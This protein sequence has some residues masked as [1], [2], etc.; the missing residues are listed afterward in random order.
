MLAC[1]LVAKAQYKVDK[2]DGKCYMAGACIVENSTDNDLFANIVLRVQK[3]SESSGME[4]FSKIDFNARHLEVPIEAKMKNASFTGTLRVDVY[5][6][7][8][9]FRI[10]EIVQHTTVL[11]SPKLTPLEK[12]QPERKPAHKAA[13]AEFEEKESE[14]LRDMQNFAKTNQLPNITHWDEIRSGKIV[15]GMNE[16]ECQLAVGKPR[17]VIDGEDETQWLINGGMYIFFKKG[18]VSSIV[19]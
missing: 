2:L 19:K 11:L 3:S 9:K 13:I 1:S 4:M 12:L 17:M 7:I 5:A 10:D 16:A 8:I 15:T 18:V 14:M 6:G